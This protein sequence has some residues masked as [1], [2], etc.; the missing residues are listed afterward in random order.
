M[1]PKILLALVAAVALL[2]SPRAARAEHIRDLADVAGAR[3]NQ[4]I[5]YGLVTGLSGTGDDTSVP[6][7]S[8][9]VLAMLRRLGVQV[10]PAQVRLR[11]VAAVIVTSTLPAFSKQGSKIDVTISSIGNAKSLSGGVLVQTLLKG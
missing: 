4:L 9:S 5:G 11:N 3:E 10:D 7:T 1:M 8:Q 2:V 6:F